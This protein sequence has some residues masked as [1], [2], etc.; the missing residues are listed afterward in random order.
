MKKIIP[1]ILLDEN[2]N[3]TGVLLKKIDFERI[4]EALEDYHDYKV[5]QKRTAKPSKSILRSKDFNRVKCNTVMLLNRFFGYKYIF[6][7]PAKKNLKKL[8]DLVS[9]KECLD[10]KM[11]VNVTPIKYRLRV[12]NYRVIFAEHENEIIIVVVSVGHRREIYNR[13]KR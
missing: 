1:N 13:M 2:G 8:D 6:S 7:N 5:I 11:L 9:S 10:I 3:K 4:M 12:G